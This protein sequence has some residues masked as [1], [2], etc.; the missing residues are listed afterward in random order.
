MMTKTGKGQGADTYLQYTLE[1][2]LTSLIETAA[3]RYDDIRPLEIITISFT[4]IK[5]KYTSYGDDGNILTSQVVGFNTAT[6]SK[7]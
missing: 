5:K 4:G 2:A 1:N 7:Y 3:L 6:N